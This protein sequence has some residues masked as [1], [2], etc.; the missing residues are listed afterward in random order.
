[1]SKFQLVLRCK[2]CRY[3]YKRVVEVAGAE[4]VDQLPNPPCPKCAKKRVTRTDAY[5]TATPA[6]AHNGL[7][8]VLEYQS[9]PGIN[10]AQIVKAIDQTAEI[11]MQ[12]Y[13]LSNLKDNVREGEIMA[14]RLPPQQQKAADQFF[15]TPVKTP[16]QNKRAQAQM[17]RIM[18]RAINGAYR[19]TALNV[20]SVL[21]DA[22]VKLRKVGVEEIKR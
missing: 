20:K 21:P 16:S 10:G 18:S 7:E 8:D 15:R 19:D 4:Y 14:P 12:D 1:M 3:K 17:H 11:V 2:A 5:E 22:R 9:A 6:I 13:H